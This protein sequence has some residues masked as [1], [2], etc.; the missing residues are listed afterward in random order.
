MADFVIRYIETP[1]AGLARKLAVFQSY[2]N[3]EKSAGSKNDDQGDNRKDES[4]V[5]ADYVLT[6]Q[7]DSNGSAC[8]NYFI[9]DTRP[10]SS[11][12]PLTID[13]IVI[14]AEACVEGPPTRAM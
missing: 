8:A 12:A 7:T 5:N 3:F 10:S 14:E 2:Q 1:K 9:L 6:F 13:D 4:T 11:H